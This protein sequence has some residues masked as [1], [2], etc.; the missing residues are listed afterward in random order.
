MTGAVATDVSADTG[1]LGHEML[2]EANDGLRARLGGCQFFEVRLR[3]DW[4]SDPPRMLEADARAF[5]VSV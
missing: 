4:V 3:I 5:L 2:D 1:G